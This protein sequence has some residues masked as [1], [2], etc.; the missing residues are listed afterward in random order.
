MEGGDAA[1]ELEPTLA[2]DEGEERQV[3]TTGEVP[4]IFRT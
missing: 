4:L 2:A 1:D 3:E